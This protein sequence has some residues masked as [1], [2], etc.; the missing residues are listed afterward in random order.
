MVA[1]SL[2]AAA[3]GLLIVR[4]R[5]GNVIRK[6]AARSSQREQRRFVT[7]G[8]WGVVVAVA[9]SGCRGGKDLAPA[10]GELRSANGMV[11]VLDENGLTL[12]NHAFESLGTTPM[13]GGMDRT[14]CSQGR[15]VVTN[16][17]RVGIVDV[18]GPDVRWREVP[19][20]GQQCESTTR[21]VIR[22]EEDEEGRAICLELVDGPP[23]TAS[24]NYFQKY[25]IDTDRW[26]AVDVCPTSGKQEERLVGPQGRFRIERGPEVEGDYGYLSS[27]VLID[28][29]SDRRLELLSRPRRTSQLD[30]QWGADERVVVVAG[31]V[32]SLPDMKVRA[33]GHSACI[34]SPSAGRERFP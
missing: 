15:V 7:R 24:C 33:E 5:K 4:S 26:Q 31:K 11:A 6:L 12:L 25:F 22:L 8:L 1:G 34:S 16:G 3:L 10:A 19:R 17:E 29:K 28:S 21:E 14:A 30:L 27:A 23:S 9:L 18:D 32:L 2:V 20:G 13:Q